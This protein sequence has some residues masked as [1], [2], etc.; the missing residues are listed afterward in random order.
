MQL[1]RLHHVQLAMPAGAEDQ[2]RAFYGQILGLPEV[3]KPAALAVR[4]GVWFESGELR[5]HL[6][7]ESDFQPARKAHPAFWVADLEALARDL[8]D[9]GAPVIHDDALPGYR[10]FYTADPFGNRIEML[11]PVS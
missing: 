3:A 10:R 9:A 2:A 4:G 5:V 7:V 6:G 1:R 8:A 11:E